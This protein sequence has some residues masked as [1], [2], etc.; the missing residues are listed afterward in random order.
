MNALRQSLTLAMR[1]TT[2]SVPRTF[3]NHPASA[4]GMAVSSA[5]TLAATTTTIA[6][7]HQDAIPSSLASSSH[8]HQQV[9]SMSRYMSKSAAKRQPLTTKRASG[10]YY[11]GK[12]GTKEGRHTRKGKYIIDRRKQ[13]ELVIPDLTDFKVIMILIMIMIITLLS[14]KAHATDSRPSQLDVVS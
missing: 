14:P 6:N 2:A 10:D 8:I 4:T 5:N 12:R 3:P 7:T 9:R 13:L 1:R 11:K